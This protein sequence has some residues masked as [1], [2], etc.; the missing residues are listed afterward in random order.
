MNIAEMISI[1][2]AMIKNKT[3]I[4]I[5]RFMTLTLEIPVK[6]GITGLKSEMYAKIGY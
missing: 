5:S 3:R 1:P 2:S 4:F 6:I